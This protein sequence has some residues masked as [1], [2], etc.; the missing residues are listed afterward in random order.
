MAIKR[1]SIITPTRS[2]EYTIGEKCEDQN[3]V[4]DLIE[5]IEGYT[6]F[7]GRYTPGYYVVY[8]KYRKIISRISSTCPIIVDWII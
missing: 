7:S 4:I 6:D 3:R 1:I 2:I 5:P 8:D